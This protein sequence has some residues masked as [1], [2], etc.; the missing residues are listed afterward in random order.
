MQTVKH[1]SRPHSQGQA[2]KALKKELRK[3][4][5]LYLLALVPFVYLILFKYWPMYGVQIA[6][7]DYRVA[8]G[9]WG[10]QWVGLKHFSR[11]LHTPKFLDIM[12]NTII[13]SLYGVLTFPLPILLAVMLNY[14]SFPRYRK[15]IQMVSYAPHFI[16]TVVMVAILMQFLDKNNG[17]LNTLIEAL[18]G[19]R[20]NFMA[21]REYF[22]HIYQW[23]GVW[24]GLGFASIIYISALSS[25]PPELHEAAIVDGANLCQRI[26][27]IDIPSILPTICI[28]LIIQCGNILSVG[29]E[30][31]YLMQNNLNA[32]TS[33]VISTYVYKQGLQS[34]TPQYSYSTAIGLFTSI[35]NLMMLMLVNKLTNK[36]SGSGLW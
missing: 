4:A 3:N 1:A 36:L 28:L 32:S 20:V 6:F 22:Y 30:K 12:K 31:I 27:H 29:Y 15:C 16:S 7:R 17:L 18:G 25:V 11:F 23:S 34:S 9:I 13:I 35:V 26:W 2:L 14:L 19:K 10:S 24:Q 21:K 33:E 5:G 8:D